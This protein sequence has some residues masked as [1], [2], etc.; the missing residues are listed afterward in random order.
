MLTNLQASQISF[1]NI[2][3]KLDEC[4]QNNTLFNYATVEMHRKRVSDDSITH[5]AIILIILKSEEY[6]HKD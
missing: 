6:C 3:P 5:D 4:S 2:E 1:K